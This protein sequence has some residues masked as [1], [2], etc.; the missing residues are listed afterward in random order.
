MKKKQEAFA[1]ALA[2]S[3]I[4]AQGTCDKMD[5]GDDIHLSLL[6]DGMMLMG[7][8]TGCSAILVVF[9]QCSRASLGTEVCIDTRGTL[10]RVRGSSKRPRDRQC[11]D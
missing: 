6:V 7:K 8:T 11:F 2:P 5:D 4:G 3:E 1:K 10:T 9:M